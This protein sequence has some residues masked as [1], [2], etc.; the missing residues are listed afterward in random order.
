MRACGKAWRTKVDRLRQE[1]LAG[2]ETVLA[3]LGR[4]TYR[5]AL[6]N[7]R[8]QRKKGQVGF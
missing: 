3:Y 2:P 8:I 7:H 1:A 6:S 4:Y 5:I